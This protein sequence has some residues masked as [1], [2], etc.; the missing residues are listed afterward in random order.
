MNYLD[1]DLEPTRLHNDIQTDPPHLRYGFSVT[2]KAESHEN[3]IITPSGMSDMSDD[4]I[5][6]PAIQLYFK[7]N[8]DR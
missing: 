8:V 5:V 1:Y 7:R 6:V 3:I 4:Q 2:A